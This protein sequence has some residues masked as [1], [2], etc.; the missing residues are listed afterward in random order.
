MTTF[1]QFLEC[2]DRL[3]NGRTREK[4]GATDADLLMALSAAEGMI[5]CLLR[6]HAPFEQPARAQ[7]L[8]IQCAEQREEQSGYYA[9]MA[10]NQIN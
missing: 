1:S 5:S 2:Y 6:M 10:G 4:V 8:F 7:E 3:P 9:R